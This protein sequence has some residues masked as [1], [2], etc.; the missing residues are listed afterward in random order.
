MEDND[1][2]QPIA[3]ELGD[4]QPITTEELGA[5]MCEFI[6]AH[7]DRV[8]AHLMVRALIVGIYMIC[9]QQQSPDE[10]LDEAAFLVRYGWEHH[11]RL[12]DAS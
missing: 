2:K 6:N 8:E 4:A 3:E 9:D 7:A 12:R 11:K 1:T 5:N 10:A